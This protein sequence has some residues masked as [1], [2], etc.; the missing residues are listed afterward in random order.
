MAETFEIKGLKEVEQ[1]IKDLPVK[2]QASVYRAINRKAVKRFVVDNIRSAVNYSAK[3]ERGIQVVNDR[4]D[5]TAVYGGVTSD[6]FPL[7]FADLGTAARY[8][9]KGAFRGAIAGK[10]QIQPIILNSVNDIIKS[11]NEEIGNE[12]IK[13]LEKRIKSTGKQI[14]K[15]GA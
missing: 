10:H 6:V 2:M 3:T 12:T 8:T 1:A 7:R 15:L 11:E 9:E 4:D 13:I 5:K 14:A